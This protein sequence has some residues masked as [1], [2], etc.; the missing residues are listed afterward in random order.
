[1]YSCLALTAQVEVELNLKFH[2]FAVVL[3]KKVIFASHKYSKTVKHILLYIFAKGPFEN[4]L[5]EGIKYLSIV[6]T[7]ETVE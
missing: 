4:A 2:Y 3:T 6:I 1:M 7:I 5:L